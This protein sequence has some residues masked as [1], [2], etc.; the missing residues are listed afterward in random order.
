[1]GFTLIEL[2]VVS[3]IVSLL[4]V[5]GLAGYYGGQKKYALSQAVQ[6]LSS[7]IRNA[8][9]MAIGGVETSGFCSA[10]SPCYG[11]GLRA[12]SSSVDSYILFADRD[13]DQRYDTGEEIE[14]ITLPNKI[15]IKAVSPSS[16]LDIVFKPPAPVTYINQNAGAGVSGSITL[17]IKGTTS[18]GTVTVTTAGLIYSN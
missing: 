17:E 3:G 14:T 15:G 18:T 13:N 8:Q 4:V 16:P 9:N 7:D 6:Q 10:A 12:D 1:M 5:A 11:Y 2:I